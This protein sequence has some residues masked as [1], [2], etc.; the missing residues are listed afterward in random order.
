[1]KM[2]DYENHRRFSLRC[3]GNGIIPVSIR[4]KNYVRTQRSDNIIH[5][6]ERSLLN[7]RIREVNMTLNSLKHDTYMYQNT[8]SGIISEDLM[9]QSIDF[10]KEHREARHKTVMERQIKKYNKFWAQKYESGRYMYSTNSSNGTGGRSN[11]D[12]I[13]TKCWVVNLSQQP[14]SQAQETVLAHGPNFAVTPKTPPLK[15]I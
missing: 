14:L 4:L 13:D 10:I 9:K 15:N 1:M 7:E 8:L 3:L 6:A 5:K 2:C 11:Q 12:K